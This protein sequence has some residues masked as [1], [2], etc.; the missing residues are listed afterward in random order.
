MNSKIKRKM[1]WGLIAFSAFTTLII[2]VTS[3]HNAAVRNRVLAD[4]LDVTAVIVDIVRVYQQQNINDFD[5]HDTHNTPRYTQRAYIAYEVDGQTFRTH[6]GWWNSSFRVGQPVDII[7]NQSNP[8]EFI[9]ANQAPGWIGIV[10]M[11][12]VAV[13]IGGGTMAAG[14]VLIQIAKRSERSRDVFGGDI[15]H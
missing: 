6:L 15:Q 4:P 2:V 8:R 14:I 9:N 3:L 1:G 13:I 11:A 10:V 7:V 5:F 12:V